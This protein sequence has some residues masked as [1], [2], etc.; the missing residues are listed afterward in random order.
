[1]DG[2]SPVYI[3]TPPMRDALAMMH[4]VYRDPKGLGTLSGLAGSGRRTVLEQFASRLR[5]EDVSAVVVDGNGMDRL[6]LLRTVLSE[7]GYELDTVAPDDLSSMLRVFLIHQC[8]A[9]QPVFLGF[10]NVSG[11]HPSALEEIC[12]LAQ[13]TAANEAAARLVL[14]CDDRLE[15]IIRAPA[16]GPVRERIT[17][18]CRLRP[19][20]LIE[21]DDYIVRHLRAAGASTHTEY[22]T[23]GA[24]ALLWRAS[25]GLPGEIE[26]LTLDVLLGGRLPADKEE[27]R[28]ALGLDD[29]AAVSPAVG[30]TA[31]ATR[32]EPPTRLVVSRDGEIVSDRHWPAG[33]VLIGRDAHN[34][35]TLPSRYISR[36]HALIVV[37][38]GR[39]WIADLKSMNGTYVNSRRV[40]QKALQ[41]D[42]VISIGNHRVKYLNP[43]ARYGDAAEEPGLADT[44]IMRSL[45]EVRHL[46]AVDE[47]GDDTVLQDAGETGTAGDKAG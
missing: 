6:A 12:R 1:M 18:G 33:R 32:S 46:F 19:L 41:H 47:A 21:T 24:I 30:D 23:D 14:A 4:E 35:V 15:Q 10:V 13:I 7:I 43:A 25:G 16:M 45:Q 9:G 34:D 2:N 26:S 17:A 39:A 28:E 31:H 3:E 40:S 29:I 36:H 44:A 42:D 20:D 5:R 38:D 27:V 8:H 37:E 11:M 22:L